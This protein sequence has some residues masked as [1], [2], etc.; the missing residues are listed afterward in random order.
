[1]F[2]VIHHQVLVDRPCT[3]GDNFLPQKEAGEVNTRLHEEALCRVP[4][5]NPSLFFS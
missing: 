4:N 1:M 3:V 5:H 2:Y